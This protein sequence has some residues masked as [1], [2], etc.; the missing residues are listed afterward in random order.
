[1][2]KGK[3]ASFTVRPVTVTGKFTI[4]EFEDFEGNTLAIY[5]LDGEAVK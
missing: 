2:V 5:R 3:S 1:M 4:S